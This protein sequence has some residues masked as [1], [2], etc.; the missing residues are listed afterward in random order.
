MIHR[1]AFADG[2]EL[3]R[4]GLLARGINLIGGNASD[5]LFGAA[6]NDVLNGGL[7]NDR[8]GGGDGDDTYLFARGDGADVV[9]G[10]GTDTL[11][12]GEGIAYEQ[13]TV[14]H[15]QATDGGRYLDLDFGGGDRVSIRDGALGT[16][17]RVIFADGRELGWRALVGMLPSLNTVA[18]D[19]ADHDGRHVGE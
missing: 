2:T 6:G 10:N 14:S 8:V 15:F 16:V 12:L 5:Q 18:T 11:R 19:K 13:M 4:K 9:V 1:F 7:G 3:D 17:E